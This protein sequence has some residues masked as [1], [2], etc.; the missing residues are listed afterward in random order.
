MPIS[1][2]VITCTKHIITKILAETQVQYDIQGYKLLIYTF[3]QI[4]FY[5]QIFYNISTII[6]RLITRNILH[7]ILSLN[8][9]FENDFFVSLRW[10]KIGSNLIFML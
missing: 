10:E 9:V 8:N 7:F 3:K 1:P 5:L 6:N 2:Y 4:H